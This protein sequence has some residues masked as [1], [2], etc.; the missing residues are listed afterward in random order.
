MQDNIFAKP[1]FVTTSVW[2]HHL[3]WHECAPCCT[4][5]CPINDPAMILPMIAGP[6]G[7]RP[8]DYAV[9]LSPWAKSPHVIRF[10]S[11]CPH[12][13]K[14]YCKLKQV[15]CAWLNK[16][17]LCLYILKKLRF[18]LVTLIPN[19]LTHSQ[20]T[21]YR[22]TQL[23]ESI[24]FKLSHTILYC[25]QKKDMWPS[26]GLCFTENH[27]SVSI[28]H[29]QSQI[30]FIAVF[31]LCFYGKPPLCLFWFSP[32]S[33]LSFN[34]THPIT[35]CTCHCVFFCDFTARRLS[36]CLGFPQDR[37]SGLLPLLK[38]WIKE[39]DQL[40]FLFWWVPGQNQ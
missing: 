1:L 11:S 26:T 30:V 27:P 14:Y 5:Q 29:I 33:T 2:D 21:E 9:H 40:N 23:V 13:Y 34:Q 32:G 39:R 35:N 25:P 17:L 31:F 6:Q 15:Y 7:T 10:M 22:A 8:E 12:I 18:G 19:T 3:L 37:P 38:D 16:G 4:L 24:K 28:I 20:T 36:A